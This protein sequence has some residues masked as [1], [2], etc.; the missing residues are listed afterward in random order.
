MVYAFHIFP[1]A[2]YALGSHPLA[3]TG[4]MISKNQKCGAWH[5][6]LF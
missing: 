5:G 6:L 2:D 3:A 4:L 1:T